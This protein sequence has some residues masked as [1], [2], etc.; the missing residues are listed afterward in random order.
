MANFQDILNKPADQIE[1]PKPL[2]VGTYVVLVEGQPEHKQ[3]GKNNTDCFEFP[4]KFLQAGPDVDQQALLENLNGKSLQDRKLK[5]RLFVTDDAVWRLKQF[6]EH[7]GI[8]I[9]SRGLGECIPESMG[10]QVMLTI[11]HRASDD[12]QQVFMDVKGT[13][14]V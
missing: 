4:L 6:L 8:E 5:H 10:R 13:A 14:K 11:G 7:L 9:G 2:P 1:A 3:M 12:G